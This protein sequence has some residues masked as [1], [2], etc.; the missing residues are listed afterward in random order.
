MMDSRWLQ[1]KEILVA[2]G[3]VWRDD[4]TLISPH[5]TM[6]FTTSS[7][8]PDHAQF[9]DA[10]SEAVAAAAEDA[11]APEATIDQ[12]ALHEDLVSLVHALD[13]ILEN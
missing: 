5:E 10:M 6:W 12:Q 3:W 8:R 7:E 1:L 2:D 11:S 13:A 4:D 9:R